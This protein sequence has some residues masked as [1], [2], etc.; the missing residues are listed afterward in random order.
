MLTSMR[1]NAGSFIIKLLLGAIV[2][3]FVLWGVGTNEKSS[4]PEVAR[5]E[6]QPISYADYAQAYQQLVDNVRRQFG[7]SLDEATLGLLNL[8]EQALNQLI[9]R[10]VLIKESQAM[11]FRVSDDELAAH[12]R[13]IPAFQSAEGF[14]RAQYDRVLTQFRMTP[15]AFEASQRDDLL[16]Q[17]ISDII[18]RT[19]K[20]SEGEATDWHRWQNAALKVAYVLFEPD[21]TAI[22]D[23]LDDEVKTYFDEHKDRY[24]TPPKRSARYLVFRSEEHRAG[25]TLAA[26]DVAAYYDEHM[27]EFEVEENVEARHILFKVDKDADQAAVDAARARAEDVYSQIKVGGDFAELAQAHSD[28]AATGAKGGYLGTF[29]RGQMVKP[30]EEA[31]FSLA[32]GEVSPPVR[33]EFGFHIIKVDQKKAAR[34]YTLTEAE[35]KIRGQLTDRRARL[36]AL[37]EAESAYD[38]SYESENLEAVAAE[39]GRALQTTDMIT[40]NQP[41][42]GVSDATAFGR[43][44]FD[45][46]ADGISEVQEIGGA[47]YI[48]QVQKIEAPQVPA[49]E[50]VRAR[51]VADWEQEL[52]WEQ[53]ENQAKAF[54]LAL[55][56]GGDLDALSNEKGLEVKNSGFFKRNE[57][58]A[59]IGYQPEIAA[60]AFALSKANPLPESPV[61]SSSGFYVFRFLERREPEGR[62]D[63]TQM[64]QTRTQLLERKRRQIFDDWMA[65]AKARTDIKIDRSVME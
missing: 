3:V 26:D 9:D 43:V 2:V 55:Q 30:F 61:R 51:V 10:A 29:G 58:I 21:Q 49:L 12:I 50:N 47:F 17:K 25:V 13:S 6:G 57:A 34:T 44:L 23:P 19:A 62:I 27:D 22:I 33:S 59:E 24:Q 52:R 38:L 18:A 63:P 39:L 64:D 20:V 56:E 37:E 7:S 16:I 5:V 45:L 32:A 35:D 28:E 48:I 15:E 46:N 31:A 14:D 36:L 41:V 4:N 53:A 65:A 42:E 8:K 54:L 11:G 40:R 1:E 60:A